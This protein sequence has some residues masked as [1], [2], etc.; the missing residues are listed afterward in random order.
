MAGNHR[1]S[2]LSLR[3]VTGWIGERWIALVFPDHKAEDAWRLRKG[4]EDRGERPLLIAG[5]GREI[6]T[7]SPRFHPS[8]GGARISELSEDDRLLDGARETVDTLNHFSST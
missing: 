6:A 4:A 1:L 8:R 7:L 5:R 3:Q 2:R